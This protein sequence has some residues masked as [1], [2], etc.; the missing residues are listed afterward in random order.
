MLHITNVDSIIHD[1]F[2]ITFSYNCYFFI[3][4]CIISYLIDLTSLNR[5]SKHKLILS[6][7]IAKMDK[8]MCH[9]S[10]FVKR[11]VHFSAFVIRYALNRFHNYF[12]EGSQVLQNSLVGMV[13]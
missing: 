1:F 5:L 8:D 7:N 4:F 3:Y 11:D 2:S 6:P 9:Y 12:Y 13:Q 10:M